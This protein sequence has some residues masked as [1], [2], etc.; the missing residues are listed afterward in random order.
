M[1]EAILIVLYA[2]GAGRQ[3]WCGYSGG[4]PEADRE[5]PLMEKDGLFEKGRFFVKEVTRYVLESEA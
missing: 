1:N 5:R 3:V 4:Y 2:D